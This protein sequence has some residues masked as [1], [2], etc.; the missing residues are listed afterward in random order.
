M[1][2]GFESL[3]PIAVYIL[4]PQAA[5]AEYYPVRPIYDYLKFDPKANDC[6]N[7]LNPALDH[8][9]CGPTDGSVFNS[10][11]N[12]PSYGDERAFLDARRSD[13][14]QSGSY[15]NVLHDVTGGSREVVLR[16]YINNDANEAFGY[17]TTAQETRVRVALPVVAGSALRARAYISAVNASPQVVEDTV[18]L[19]DTNRFAVEF[20][21]GS[22]KVYSRDGQHD[23]SD[24]I[25]DRGALIT[26]TGTV[27]V[28]AAGFDKDAQVQVGLRIVR[29]RSAPRWIVPAGAGLAALGLLSWPWLRESTWRVTQRL[30]TWQD[31]QKVGIQIVAS[32]IAA[33]LFA[34]GVWLVQY[35]S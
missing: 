28:F 13:Q 22:A 23:L 31:S 14:T 15:K 16:I 34:A 20:I 25:V 4:A 26:N 2:R 5:L 33:G 32:L 3:V 9:R 35:V 6:Q 1:R 27:G 7:L 17:K 21:P 19:V 12:T 24:E 8:G 30:W 10:F 29:E 11:I 18:D